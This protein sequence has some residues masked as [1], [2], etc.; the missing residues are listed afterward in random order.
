MLLGIL[1]LTIVSYVHA[2]RF[3]HFSETTAQRTDP[4]NMT[5]SDKIAII[6]TGIENPH[7]RDLILPQSDYKTWMIE[8]DKKLETWFIP[9]KENKGLILF[10]HGYAGNKS[11]MV[12]RAEDLYKLGYSTAIIGFRGSGNSEGNYTTIGFEESQDV[13]NSYYY[14]KE[15]LPDQPIFLFGSSMGAA[16]ILKAF[17]MEALP[18]K[19]VILEYPFGSL[20]QSVQNRFEVMGFPSF[21]MAAMLTYFG[22]WQ[23]NFDAFAHNPS[24]YAKSVTC[25][26]LHLAGDKDDRVKNDETE[27]IFQN[28]NSKNKTLHVFKSAGHENLNETFRDK[29]LEVCETFLAEA[30]N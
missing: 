19:G 1:A 14:Y 3:T 6:L 20:Y 10:Y 2:Y 17:E 22:G 24:E 4:K 26:V 11:Q 29:W 30:N 13:I 15:K 9:N 12:S 21:P 18:V 7:Q 5:V 25:P 23:L 27:L 28:L 8:G 16:A